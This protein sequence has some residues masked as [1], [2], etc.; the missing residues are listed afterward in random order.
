MNKITFLII[1]I[2]LYPFCTLSNQ[3]KEESS[4]VALEITTTIKKHLIFSFE[5]HKNIE[6]DKGWGLF[7]YYTYEYDTRPTGYGTPGFEILV[8][9]AAIIFAIVWKKKK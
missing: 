8:T 3:D 7:K 4:N 5:F 1:A 2:V 6:Y 9:L